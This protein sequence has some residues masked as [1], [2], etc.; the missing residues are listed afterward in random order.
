MSTKRAVSTMQWLALSG[1]LG[2]A[3]V[4]TAQPFIDPGNKFSWQENCGWMNWRDAGDG[5]QG[6]RVGTSFLGGYIWCEN[7]GWVN[8]GSGSPSNGTS[9]ANANGLDFGVNMNPTTG[10]LSGFAWGENVGWIN[11]SGG[12]L[13]TPANPARLDFGAARF[14]G[15]AWGENI[16]WVNLDD[17]NRYV[18]VICRADFNGD[19][20]VDF[21]DYLDFVQAF[22]VED[23]S[24]DFNGDGQVDFF[25]YLD[26]VQAFGRG[27]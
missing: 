13:A 26:F 5:T 19:G 10:V 25:D 21:F 23:P 17:A 15:Y 1:A 11:F 22:D 6:V 3:P 4:A 12:A 7:I 8:V 2:L 16:G 24:A 20:Q 18:G 9:Y 14:R 27:C